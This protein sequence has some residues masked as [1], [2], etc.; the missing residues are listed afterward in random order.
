MISEPVED[1][2]LVI[3][4]GTRVQGQEVTLSI[5]DTSNPIRGDGTPLE[6]GI[7]F[8]LH[9]STHNT[10]GG[11]FCLRPSDF[12]EA[13]EQMRNGGYSK[14]DIELEIGPVVSKGPDWLW[15]TSND[16]ALSS[17]PRA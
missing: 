12:A 10:I 16:R 3:S 7:G 6:H 15:Q 9:H 11:W 17:K 8:L 13:W 14:C 2:N 1:S 5:S 4:D